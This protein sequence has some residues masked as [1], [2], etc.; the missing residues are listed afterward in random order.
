[1]IVTVTIPRS[2]TTS[3]NCFRC[4]QILV[5]S[6][7]LYVSPRC[8]WTSALLLTQRWSCPWSLR[9]SNLPAI[10]LVGLLGLT[11]V[12]LLGLQVTA[13]SHLPSLVLDLILY[14]LLRE[15]LDTQH[16]FLLNTQTQVVTTVS[17]P[18]RF[19]RLVLHVQHILRQWDS[20]KPPLLP[21]HFKRVNLQ[22]THPFT[23][24]LRTS[25]VVTINTKL[26]ERI[27]IYQNKKMELC[28]SY[29]FNSAAFCIMHDTE[30]WPLPHG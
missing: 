1:M 9:L 21:L 4:K 10:S 6:V 7:Y 8:I 20:I 13:T 5:L 29:Y 12:E 23:P 27:Q 25:T 22:P 11:Q 3:C 19:L 2:T 17:G 16:H 18:S 28:S 14:L 30:S 26:Q 24:P 15:L